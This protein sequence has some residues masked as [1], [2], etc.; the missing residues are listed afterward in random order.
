MADVSK[1]VLVPYSAHQMFDLVN[2]CEDYPAFLPWCAGGRI[3]EQNGNTLSAEL[4]IDFKGIQQAF[5]TQNV[6]IPGQRIEMRLLEGPFKS[7]EGLWLF[8]PLS[9]NACK[10]EF[11]LEYH[12]K[13]GLLEKLVGPVFAHITSTFV[14]AFVSRAETIYSE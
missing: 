1:T 9:E 11:R 14:E 3:L 5:S 13:N 6:T 4:L 8:S 7:L 2:N 10:V 12:F